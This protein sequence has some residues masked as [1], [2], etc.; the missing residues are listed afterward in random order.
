MRKHLWIPFAALVVLLFA[1][2][3]VYVAVTSEAEPTEG[4][5]LDPK[6]TTTKGTKALTELLG[7]YD[8]SISRRAPKDDT[9]T[10]LLFSDSFNETT[11]DLLEDWTR[12]GGRL[13]IATDSKTQWHPEETTRLDNDRLGAGDCSL[14]EF[15]GYRIKVGSRDNGFQPGQDFGADYCFD[16]G[17]GTAFLSQTSFGRGE[18][19]VVG[20]PAP[21]L[22]Q[23]LAELDNAAFALTLLQPNGDEKISILYDWSRASNS[24]QRAKEPSLWDA[25]PAR[26]LWAVLQLCI[27]FFVF[28]MWKAKR[29]GDPVEETDLVSLPGSMLVEATG[30]FYRRSALYSKENQAQTANPVPPSPTMEMAH[31]PTIAQTRSQR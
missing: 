24:S 17:N 22:N 4:P 16:D 25:L 18:I 31:N 15:E 20:S 3:F 26:F 8:S 29:F 13:V 21:F 27:A 19:I 5:A 7:E 12:D 30:E 10:V 28:T 11:S 9:D 1:G 2:G 14:D 6:V 23:N